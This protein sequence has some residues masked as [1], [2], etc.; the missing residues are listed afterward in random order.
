MEN[1][2]S[3]PEQ[4]T[5]KAIHKA[6]R[7]YLQLPTHK[8]LEI[9]RFVGYTENFNNWLSLQ[10]ND[11]PF[12]KWIRDN[13]KQADFVKKLIPQPSEQQEE[14]SMD[15]IIDDRD[16]KNELNGADGLKDCPFCGKSPVIYGQKNKKTGN[17]VYYINC[18]GLECSASV[19]CCA[20]E[21]DVARNLVIKKW[22]NR[23]STPT[24]KEQE[25]KK[26]MVGFEEFE[27]V[28][29][30]ANLMGFP[31]M[32]AS[33]DT[34]AEAWQELIKSVKVFMAYHSGISSDEL[35]ELDGAKE[36]ENEDKIIIDLLAIMEEN[37]SAIRRAKKLKMKG[38]LK[39]NDPFDCIIETYIDLIGIIK[40]LPLKRGKGFEEM[41][42]RINEHA[43]QF[44]VQPPS[45]KQEPLVSGGW[46]SDEDIAVELIARYNG[47][48]RGNKIAKRSFVDAIEW[49]KS[50][51]ETPSSELEKEVDRL[52]KVVF[53]QA[54]KISN[55]KE[56]NESLATSLKH[57]Q[58]D[59]LNPF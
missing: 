48:A 45:Q 19:F 37:L 44:Q 36:Q 25:P 43:A 24:P 9:W 13:S 33:G 29:W 46:P 58:D 16:I 40:N 56:R 8:K 57:S 55:L 59:H 30:I 15:M 18:P 11:E 12:F 21:L 50:K 7:A 17:I 54:I 52:N 22:N 6:T 32:I 35:K 42:I 51:V 47:N 1:K 26:L 4:P 28:E 2:S 23:P 27:G 20:S 53:D 38:V 3:Q 14:E 5:S 39:N 49:I 10:E 41:V 34:K 31:G